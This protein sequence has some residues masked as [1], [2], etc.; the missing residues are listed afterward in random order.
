MPRSKYNVDKDVAKRTYDGIVFASI[1]EMKYYKDVLLPGVESGEVVY[2]ELQKKYELQPGFSRNGRKVLP[3]TYVAD[4]Y[5]EYRNGHTQ[6]ID[7]KG[8][9]DE[10]AKLK[11]KILLY[12]Y[13]EIDYQWI[14]Y[15]AKYGGWVE[16][17]TL[18]K[19]RRDA[20]KKQKED[21]ENVR[22]S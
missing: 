22:K 8:M 2:Y 11:K 6:V 9:P 3:I 20:K 21:E 7:T 14:R 5:I 19:L 10:K 17:E 18:K 1:L 13:P 4:F 15:V 12:K 16:Y